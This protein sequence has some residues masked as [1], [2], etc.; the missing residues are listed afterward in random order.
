MGRQ[1]SRR[2]ALALGGAGLATTLGASACGGDSASGKLVFTYWGTTIEKQAVSKALEKFGGDAEIDDQH[3][4]N[5]QYDT[6]MNALL[7]SD[8]LPDCA[9]MSPSLALR[10]AEQGRLA[11]MLEQSKQHPAL[12]GFMPD[13]K[14]FWDDDKAIYSWALETILLYYRKDA[15]DDAGIEAPVAGDQAWTWDRF[16]EVAQELTIDQ[17]GRRASESGFNPDQVK[18][19]GLYVPSITNYHLWYPLL[20]SNG[21]RFVDEAGK[22]YEL[23]SPEAAE[24]LQ[25]LQDLVYKYHVCPSPSTL[26]DNPP[27]TTIQLQSERAAMA[28]DGFWQLLDLND[29]GLDYG[30]G[31][32]PRYQDPVTIAVNSPLVVPDNSDH[33]DEAIELLIYLSKPEN[34]DLYSR[35]LWMPGQQKY[36]EDPE[37]IKSWSNE[38][39]GH[40]VFRSAIVDYVSQY[41][42]RDYHK[43]LRNQ[44]AIDDRLESGLDPIGLNDAPAADALAALKDKVEPLL[45]GAYPVAQ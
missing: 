5:A 9:Y 6:K 43:F 20:L 32:L 14:F 39:I 36:Y 10:M 22:R 24:V 27:P 31:V 15:F 21:G 41:G 12:D 7:A 25:N 35:G 1:F 13:I 28:I 37:L 44:S 26:G 30:V 19:Y 38:Q 33:R 3:I 34:V 17:E 4:P 42:Q 16:V 2:E 45:Q 11:N 40:D 29:S 23:D 8:N 18:R